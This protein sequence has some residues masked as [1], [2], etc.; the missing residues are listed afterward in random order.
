MNRVLAS[1][2]IVYNAT[3]ATAA[4]EYG[5]ELARNRSYEE[6]VP[7]ALAQ[8][9]SS[10]ETAAL[11]EQFVRQSR[12]LRDTARQQAADGNQ[13]AAVRTMQ[14]ATGQLQKALRIAGLTVPQTDGKP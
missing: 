7:I 11:S 9:N 14:E 13:Q 1:E 3:F 2:T 10:R 8:L 12:T 6:L 5:Y 4:E